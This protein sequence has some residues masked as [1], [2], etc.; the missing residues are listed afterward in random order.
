MP[1]PPNAI[2]KYFPPIWL[3]LI[4]LLE[5]SLTDPGAEQWFHLEKNVV[6]CVISD[7][8]YVYCVLSRT[9]KPCIV[10]QLSLWKKWGPIYRRSCYS[11]RII[12]II[13]YSQY[14]EFCRLKF[15]SYKDH[16]NS[17]FSNIQDN[18]Q[19]SFVMPAKESAWQ[20]S[21][22][23]QDNSE[24]YVRKKRKFCFLNRLKCAHHIDSY[25]IAAWRFFSLRVSTGRSKNPTSMIS[26]KL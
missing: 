25:S 3:G 16:C 6:R 24:K 22:I 2:K 7:L 11:I 23:T 5:G 26:Q 19:L 8:Q 4:K 20:L 21:F 14:R 17:L 1:P 9:T 10:Y 12:Y 18:S 13:D 15:P